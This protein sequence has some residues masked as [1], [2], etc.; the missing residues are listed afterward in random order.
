MGVKKILFLC[1]MFFI[2]SS[3]FIAYE[4]NHYNIVSDEQLVVVRDKLKTL[5]PQDRKDLA[6]F[7]DEA[8]LFDEYP[9]TLVGYKP[10]SIFVFSEDSEDLDEDLRKLYE[11]PWHQTMHRGYLVWKKYQSFF[12]PQKNILIEYHRSTN[13]GKK[14]IALISRNLCES[15]IEE[16]LSDFCKVLGRPC[17][18]KEILEILTNPA[19]IDFHAIVEHNRLLGILLGFGR[20]NACLYERRELAEHLLGLSDQQSLE[21]DPLSSL[22]NEWPFWPRKWRLPGFACDPTTEETK[23]LKKQYQKARR[24]IRWTYFNRDN[25]EVTLALLTQP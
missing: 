10:M 14:E 7:I 5:S 17:K 11:N 25:L 2:C 6:V 16:H 9:Y 13:K 22:T 19:N 4:K 8:I 15:K 21:R 18:S 20:N 24:I 12:P 1:V 23:Q 3:A